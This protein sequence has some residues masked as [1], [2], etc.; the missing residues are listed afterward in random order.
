MVLYTKFSRLSNSIITSLKILC[1]GSTVVGTQWP[2][3]FANYCIYLIDLI[4]LIDLVIAVNIT[5]I[6]V[7][8][9][10]VII[11]IKLDTFFNNIF[12]NINFIILIYSTRSA[13]G[14]FT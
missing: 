7:T 10:I 13:V 1:W 11:V 8:V 6:V 5:D 14:G 3:F 9:I 12:I 4:D 2:S